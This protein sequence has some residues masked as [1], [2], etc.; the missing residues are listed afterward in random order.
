LSLRNSA[1]VLPAALAATLVSGCLRA[2]V[3]MGPILPPEPLPHLNE[4]DAAHRRGYL[5]RAQVWHEVPTASLDLLAGPRVPGAFAF[6]EELTCDYVPVQAARLNGLTPK[7]LCRTTDEELRVK[8]G[9]GNGEVYAEV[10]ASRL[11]WALGFRTDSVYPVRVVC[12]GCPMD[13]WLW[14][15]AQR[16]PEQRYDAATVERKL[17]GTTIETKTA[18]GWSWKEL[19]LVD[20]ALGGAPAAQRDALKLLAVF[21]QHGDNKPD[22]QRLVCL[23]EGVRRQETGEV[24]DKPFLAVSDL[25]ATFGGAGNMSR[26]QVAKMRYGHWVKKPVFRDKARCIGELDASVWGHLQHPRIGEAGRRFLAQRL[27]LLSDRQIE[28]MFKAARVEMRGETLTENGTKRAVTVADWV[29][30]F[31]DKRHEIEEQRC[32]E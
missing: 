7:F 15:T 22:Q 19:D 26:D 14:K 30:A 8:Y 11:F 27:A 9:Q 25:G 32:P 20:P 13:P 23:P 31:K 5:Q 16:V 18:G 21:V 4:V 12:R 2:A 10:A 29:R 17:A 24:C 3:P 28:D 1:R 6:D